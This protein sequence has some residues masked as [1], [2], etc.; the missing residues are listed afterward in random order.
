MPVA[1]NQNMIDIGRDMMYPT[2]FVKLQSRKKFPIKPHTKD[3]AFNAISLHR[4]AIVLSTTAFAPTIEGPVWRHR[5]HQ[6][7]WAILHCLVVVTSSLLPTPQ[8]IEHWQAA[9]WWQQ[10]G[11]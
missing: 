5:T 4:L 1:M 8:L 6:I 2:R 9:Q 7:H 11:E 10:G 3:T